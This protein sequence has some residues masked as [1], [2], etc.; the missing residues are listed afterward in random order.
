MPE[1]ETQGEEGPKKAGDKKA[2]TQT[3]GR[4]EGK[5]PGQPIS[6]DQ[7]AA[8]LRR[9]PEF[10]ADN[11]DLLDSQKPPARARG[12]GIVDLQQFQVQRLRDELGDLTSLRDELISAGRSNLS[13]QSRVHQAVLAILNARSFEE[14]VET[15][16]TDMA[17]ILD[18]DVVTIGVEKTEEGGAWRPMAGVYCLEAGDIDERLGPSANILLREEVE[19][20]PTIFDGAAGLVRS[21]AL[22][23]LKISDTTPPALLALGSRQSAAFHAG[24]GTELLGF[25]SRVLEVTFRAWLNLPPKP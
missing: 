9:H 3:K 18:L 23:R 1:S 16:T 7:V 25:L 22:I 17:A 11:P 21:D 13:T 19:G 20:D 8:Y 6:A 12:K 15:I 14:F 5:A 4:E 10:L 2:S 24:Q